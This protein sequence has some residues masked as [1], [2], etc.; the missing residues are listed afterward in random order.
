M[1]HHAPAGIAPAAARSTVARVVAAILIVLGAAGGTTAC[2]T[3]AATRPEAGDPAPGIDISRIDDVRDDFPAG[4][5]V[6]AGR[7][8]T[9]TA[10]DIARTGINTLTESTLHPAH[11]LPAIIPPYADISIGTVA[12]GVTGR[13]AQGGVQVTA[14]RL[15]RPVPATAPPAGC[16]LVAITAA[17]AVTGAAEAVP[18]PAIAG[19]T[20]RGVKLSAAGQTEP[21]YILTAA[22]D[23]QTTVVVR[24][25]LAAALN[26]PQLLSN[27]LVKAV[28]A[29]RRS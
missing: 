21:D 27:L 4:F 17:P 1:I 2:G 11:C 28:A 20:T 22:L 29:V 25:N 6:R 23:D 15:P 19:A 13:G 16:D 8:R 14:L 3:T 7:S 5:T 9:F 26:P 18:L 24:G 10:G 12:A